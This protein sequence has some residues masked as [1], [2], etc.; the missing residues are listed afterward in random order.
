MNT[1]SSIVIHEYSK[2][3]SDFCN[4]DKSKVH[5]DAKIN[6]F[7]IWTECNEGSDTRG[8]IYMVLSNSSGEV[9]G[10]AAQRPG[11]R[12]RWRSGCLRRCCVHSCLCLSSAGPQ[13]GE[14]DR[15]AAIR[16]RERERENADRKYDEENENAERKDRNPLMY[17]A[18]FYT[19]KDITKQAFSFSKTRMS[20]CK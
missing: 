4:N 15:Q 9:L 18:S 14:G 1:L 11:W 20:K 19:C 7:A 6:R 17:F 2:R 13:A 10:S 3:S 8:F 12:R 16:Y 5:M